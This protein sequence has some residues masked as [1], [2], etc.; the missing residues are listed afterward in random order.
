MHFPGLEFTRASA[1]L[2]VENADQDATKSR[3]SGKLSTFQLFV[4]STLCSKET[5][6]LVYGTPQAL[7]ALIPY[8]YLC[9][10]RYLLP[11]FL[12]VELLTFSAVLAFTSVDI[13]RAPLPA[14]A[15]REDRPPPPASAVDER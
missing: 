6:E 7:N 8:A 4:S 9:P 5:L 2:S 13:E 11:L 3:T 10:N 14:P 1:A 15:L 12:I